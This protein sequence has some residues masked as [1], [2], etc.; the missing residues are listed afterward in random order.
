MITPRRALVRPRV[1]SAATGE[2][3]LLEEEVRDLIASRKGGILR[4]VGSEGAGKTTALEHLADALAGVS[5]IH[6]VD[7]ASAEN[8]ASLTPARSHWVVFATAIRCQELTSTLQLAPWGQD[9]WIEYL[10]AAHQDRCAS[11]MTRLRSGPRQVALLGNPELW[12]IAL[13]QMAAYDTIPT[14]RDALLH[15][16]DEQLSSDGLRT[17]AQKAGLVAMLGDVHSGSAFLLDIE[18]WTVLKQSAPLVVRLLGQ[19]AVRLL[20]AAAHIVSDLEGHSQCKYFRQAFPHLLIRET[21][22]LVAQR[23]RARNKLRNWLAPRR[24]FHRRPERHAMAA[25]ILHASGTGWVPISGSKPTLAGAYLP[26]VAW[27]KMVLPGVN[28]RGADLSHA[29]LRDANL[30]GANAQ[31]TNLSH[32]TACGASLVGLAATEANLAR[33]DLSCSQG[34]G[35][36]LDGADLEG[37]RWH[38]ADLREASFIGAKLAGADFGGADLSGATFPR[39]TTW[40]EQISAMPISRARR[41]PS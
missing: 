24:W 15:F 12:R 8:L 26:H 6:F 1:L 31:G 4:L 33:A 7:D 41:F 32:A 13:D 14:A 22:A 10:Q 37:S 16:L 38:D 3:L 40:R 25:S 21:G 30:D 36:K 35:A 34:Q 18:E 17:I 5:N 28:L 20:L 39:S 19:H 9:E 29:D 23:P 2:F 27:F 11:V